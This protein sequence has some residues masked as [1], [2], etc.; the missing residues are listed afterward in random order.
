MLSQNAETF[1][2]LARVL[3]FAIVFVHVA[4]LVFRKDYAMFASF[5]THLRFLELTLLFKQ[6]SISREVL[7]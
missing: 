1:T 2:V 4:L 6:K 3:F 5:E 7:V